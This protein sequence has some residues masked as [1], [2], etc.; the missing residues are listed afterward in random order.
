MLFEVDAAGVAAFE[1]ER[2]A[3]WS[4]HMDRIARGFEAS[5]GVE[6]G[7]NNNIQAI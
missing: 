7:P 4:I 6:I 1:L 3:P 2:D 5:E